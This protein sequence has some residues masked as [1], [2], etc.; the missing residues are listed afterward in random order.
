MNGNHFT[1]RNVL[2]VT[3]A[4]IVGGVTLTGQ[5]VAQEPRKVGHHGELVWGSDGNEWELLDASAPTP[6]GEP[7]HRPLY[8]IEPIP[9]GPEGGHPGPQSPPGAH[10]PAHDHVID[11]PGSGGGKFSAEWHVILVTEEEQSN[12]MDAFADLTNQDGS[13]NFIKTVSDIETAEDAG[14]VEFFDTGFVF[15]CPVRPHNHKRGHGRD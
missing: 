12:P 3:A 10:G 14:D 2:K 6:A 7:A 5:T 13:G 1:R 4:G 8:V 15:T 9:D 11:T